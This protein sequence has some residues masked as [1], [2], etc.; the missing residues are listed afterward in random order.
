VEEVH[1]TAYPILPPYVALFEP[2]EQDIW[3]GPRLR[4]IF[5]NQPL[6]P[7]E[8]QEIEK[9]KSLVLKDIGLDTDAQVPRW[10]LPHMTRVLQ[11]SKYKPEE[12][13]KVYRTLYTERVKK[14]PIRYSDVKADLESGF[15]YWHGRDLRA[16]P[17]MVISM[18]RGIS[19]VNRADSADAVQ[20]LFLFHM[21]FGVRHLL[22]PGRVETWAVS[23]TL[24]G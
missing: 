4:A 18:G 3:L 21:E 15:V 23:S 8:Q 20:R 16:R 2:Q 5:L 7:W 22:V 17:M 24:H 1:L 14:L 11:Q 13:V 12:A 9:F 19:F 6:K 10:L